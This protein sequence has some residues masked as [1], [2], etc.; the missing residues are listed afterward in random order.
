MATVTITCAFCHKP[1]GVLEHQRGRVVRCPHCRQVVVVPKEDG[2]GAAEAAGAK[3]AVPGEAMAP[4]GPG[5]TEGATSAGPAP[6]VSAPA[7]PQDVAADAPTVVQAVVPLP[8][9]RPASSGEDAA[10][11]LSEAPPTDSLFDFGEELPRP[12]L[13]PAEEGKAA[14]VCPPGSARPSATPQTPLPPPRAPMP[15]PGTAGSSPAVSPPT[16]PPGTV[17]APLPPPP[18]ASAPPVSAAPASAPAPAPF[19]A[20]APADDPGPFRFGNAGDV[21]TPPLPIPLIVPVEVPVEV[22][23]PSSVAARPAAPKPLH[24]S[25]LAFAVLALYAAFAT[26]V[27]LY[28]LFF[29]EPPLPPAHPLAILPDTFGE[30][31]PASRK[32]IALRLPLTGPL[33]EELIVPLGGALTVGQLRVEP[34]RVE[35]RPLRLISESAQ[36]KREEVTGPALVLHL[37]LTNTSEDLAFHPVDPALVRKASQLEQE[38]RFN[39]TRLHVGS[40]VYIGGPLEWPFRRGVRR[41]EAAQ[42]D[43]D[44]PLQPGETRAFVICS[45]TDPALRRALR[46]A[47]ADLL[48]HVHLRTGIFVW[49]EREIPVTSILGVRFPAS[50]IRRS[51]S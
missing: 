8:F 49:K 45:S 36:E 31:D 41:Y 38:D 48:W 35:E 6:A 29:R 43:H 21:P 50:A 34:L 9:S 5:V 28:G 40:A 20:S 17:V 37:K 1:M 15:G 25:P 33:P 2:A 22:P 16:P 47:P 4:A 13:P 18:S 51:P 44:R 12:I 7:S 14:P 11:I 24:I 32:K 26:C 3:E 30:Y 10:S 23:A 27:A 19:P 39:G 46:N 42:H